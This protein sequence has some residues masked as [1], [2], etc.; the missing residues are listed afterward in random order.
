M[1]STPLGK[2]I[3]T[4]APGESADHADPAASSVPASTPASTPAG[5][6]VEAIGPYDPP[7]YVKVLDFVV[8]HF[9]QL[10]SVAKI[11]DG[12]NFI[13]RSPTGLTAA[14]EGGEELGKLVGN[15]IDE[16]GLFFDK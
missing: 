11:V 13:A 4:T 8:D 3:P 16:A 7:A 12:R 15:W 14:I 6:G 5:D 1:R 9:A 10:K 2:T